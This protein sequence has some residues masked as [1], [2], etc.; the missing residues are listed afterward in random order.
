MNLE[1]VERMFSTTLTI[2]L[3]A[4]SPED[5]AEIEARSNA[6]GAID[7]EAIEIVDRREL[8]PCRDCPEGM[9]W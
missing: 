1:H 6:N 2:P 3:S 9:E 7:V 5:I 8:P 4:L